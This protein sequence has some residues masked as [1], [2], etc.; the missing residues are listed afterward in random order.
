MVHKWWNVFQSRWGI[1]EHIHRLQA[2]DLGVVQH[3][4]TPGS[5][6]TGVMWVS[7][8]VLLLEIHRVRGK[9]QFD[10]SN[11]KICAK[12][13]GPQTVKKSACANLD[14]FSH[15]LILLNSLGRW[16]L[17]GGCLIYR[18]SGSPWGCLS[19]KT[20]D[21]GKLCLSLNSNW[22][23]SGERVRWFQE[24]CSIDRAVRLIPSKGKRF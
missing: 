18:S 15:L 11:T 23:H 1:K 14:F 3:S 16:W 2:K 7:L 13:I 9:G 10:L 17:G 8:F 12:F 22:E 4:I 6:K 5:N 19:V 24:M 20:A 21:S